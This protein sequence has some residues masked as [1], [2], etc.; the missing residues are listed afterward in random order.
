MEFLIPQVPAGQNHLGKV[1]SPSVSGCRHT[2]HTH[3]ADTSVIRKLIFLKN[4][5]RNWHHTFLLSTGLVQKM[6]AFHL[7]VSKIFGSFEW[8]TSF[9][10][11]A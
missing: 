7:S 10:Y 1:S 9:A 8:R 5:S 4:T 2:S 3:S 11:K 6:S